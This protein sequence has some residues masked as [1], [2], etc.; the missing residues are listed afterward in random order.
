MIQIG[1]DNIIIYSE[2][3]EYSSTFMYSIK[4][5]TGSWQLHTLQYEILLTLLWSTP[6]GKEQKG[7][8]GEI[9]TWTFL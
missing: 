7:G 5:K 6:R 2:I 8:L 3:S 4:I 9:Y 1:P